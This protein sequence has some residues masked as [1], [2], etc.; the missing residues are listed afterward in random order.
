VVEGVK[1][2][3]HEVRRAAWLAVARML[4]QEKRA[5]LAAHL[6]EDGKPRLK[7]VRPVHLESQPLHIK[8]AGAFPVANA[9]LRKDMLLYRWG[10]HV[11]EDTAQKVFLLQ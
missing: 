10:V 8:V 7:L 11:S 3:Q 5:P 1:V 4:G 2:V 9:Q 6:R